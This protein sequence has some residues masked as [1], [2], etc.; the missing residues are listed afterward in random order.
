MSKT[1]PL[2]DSGHTMQR[3]ES[4]DNLTR[5]TGVVDSGENTPPLE[6]LGKGT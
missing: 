5:V 1:P 2:F 3:L 4:L 6:W